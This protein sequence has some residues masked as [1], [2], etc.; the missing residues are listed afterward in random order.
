LDNAPST[1]TTGSKRTCSSTSAG[2][3]NHL[4]FNAATA[5]S[6]NALTL[7]PKLHICQ[8]HAINAKMLDAV[9]DVAFTR[10]TPHIK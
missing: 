4:N 2:N 1:T 7:R 8:Y 6:T 5:T 3:N 9:V 10:V